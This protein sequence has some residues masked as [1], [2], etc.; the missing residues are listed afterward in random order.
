MTKNPEHYLTEDEADSVV[1]S[2]R[3]MKKL[4]ESGQYQFQNPDY[5]HKCLS[6]ALF[7]LTEGK[8]GVMIPSEN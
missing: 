3:L 2:V 6:S 1:T 4:L 5:I 8:E 7:K